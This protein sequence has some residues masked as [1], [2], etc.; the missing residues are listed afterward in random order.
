MTKDEYDYLSNLEKKLAVEILRTSYS[1]LSH[2]DLLKEAV[3]Q[4]DDFVRKAQVAKH[5]AESS[6]FNEVP[7]DILYKKELKKVLTKIKDYSKGTWD[8]VI[9]EQNSPFTANGD[10]LYTILSVLREAYEQDGGKI[11]SLSATRFIPQIGKKVFFKPTNTP[12]NK[13]FAPFHFC[14]EKM[15]KKGGN[16]LLKGLTKYNGTREGNSLYVAGLLSRFTGSPIDVQSDGKGLTSIALY[17]PIQSS[18]SKN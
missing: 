5:V 8:I 1:H 11:H 3:M 10:M 12:N 6:K 14:G 9:D 4:A 7:L 17:Y 16:S 2:P 13:E 18:Y 15:I